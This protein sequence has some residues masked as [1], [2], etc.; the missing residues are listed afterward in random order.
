MSATEPKVA[1]LMG[2]KN[3]WNIMQAAC[4]QLTALGIANEARVISAHRTPQL[5]AQLVQGRLLLGESA[6]E[7]SHETLEPRDVRTRWALG[8]RRR[9]LRRLMMKILQINL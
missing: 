4:D 6:G 7:A 2:S 1:V 5:V 9:P 8:R 3:D